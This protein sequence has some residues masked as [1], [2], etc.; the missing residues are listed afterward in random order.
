ML[1][2]LL[3]KNLIFQGQIFLF[4]LNEEVQKQKRLI[5]EIDFQW[6]SF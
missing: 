6:I 1:K 3:D 5:V 4:I 2:Q